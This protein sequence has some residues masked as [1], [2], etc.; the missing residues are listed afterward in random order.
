[1]TRK[2]IREI[3]NK[4]AIQDYNINP[5]MSIDVYRQVELINKNLTKLPLNFNKIEGDFLCH[6]NMLTSLE[7]AP[8]IVNGFFDCSHN[9]LSTLE[10]APNY[11]KGFFNC[12]YNNLTSLKYSPEY[13]G[14]NF[15][16]ANNII[17]NLNSLKSNIQGNLFLENN[18]IYKLYQ[19]Y[20]RKIDNIELFNDYK[21][22]IDN[23]LYLNRL[24]DY[25]HSNNYKPIYENYKKGL[26][27][28]GYTL[29]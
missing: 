19:N 22:I 6:D 17:M 5:D 15:W 20:I 14:T 12:S 26:I 27:T 10:G 1:M 21:I 24:N 9:Y 2:E 3:C 4:Y 7:G 25:L 28:N 29:I 11:V 23:K 18:P 8:K 13:V 16:C